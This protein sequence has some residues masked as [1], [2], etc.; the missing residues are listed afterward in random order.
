MPKYK[1]ELE[2]TATSPEQAEAVVATAKDAV[3]RSAVEAMFGQI[4]TAEGQQV[5]TGGCWLAHHSDWSGFAVFGS[6]LD[7]LRH[8]VEHSMTV[9]FAEWGMGR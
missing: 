7:A 5:R 1:I 2:I 6:E 9:V 8:A 4:F 3:Q